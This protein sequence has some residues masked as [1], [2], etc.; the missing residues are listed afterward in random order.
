[1]TNE[2]EERER[3]ERAGTPAKDRSSRLSDGA[4][5]ENDRE[6]IAMKWLNRI[7]QG[8]S[9]GARCPI[10]FVLKGRPTVPG[11]RARSRRYRRF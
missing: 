7:S 5:A 9:P 3:R 2:R 10:D 8:F 4:K 6:R 11:V 1:M